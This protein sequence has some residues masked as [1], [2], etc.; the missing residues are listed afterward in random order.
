MGLFNA[1]VSQTIWYGLASGVAFWGLTLYKPK[2]YYCLANVQ[3]I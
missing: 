1:K 2:Y 3:R